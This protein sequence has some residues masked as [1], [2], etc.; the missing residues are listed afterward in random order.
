MSNF[1]ADTLDNIGTAINAPE[2]G[3]SESAAGG[4]TTNT[5]R[6]AG[7]QNNLFNTPTSTGLAIADTTYLS[8]L[9][10]Q[11]SYVPTGIT[12]PYSPQNDV[13]GVYDGGDVLGAQARATANS[14]AQYDQAIGT[15]NSSL[16]RLNT[17]ADIARGNVNTQYGTQ[18]GEL[19]TNKTAQQGTYN[20]QTTQN[21]QNLRTNKNTIADQASTGLRGLQRMLGAYGAGGSSDAMFVAP[22]A[23][24]NQASQQ[25]AG[26]GQTFAQN[27]SGLDTNWNNFLGQDTNSRKKLNDWKSN[28]LNS[29]ESQT[30]S[31][32]QDLLSKLADLT[33]QRAAAAGGS[34]AASAQP[35]MDQANALNGTIDNLGRTVSTYD[36]TRPVYEAPTLSSYVSQAATGRIDPT[37][38]TGG[39][40]PYLSMLLNQNK[41]KTRALF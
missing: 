23:V 2:F 36:G 39:V 9:L 18:L 14:L 7:T 35:F 3:W 5:G 20:N 32:R 4:K 37:Q 19:D 30:A 13:S 41:D 40:N 12:S 21:G 28:T 22:Q 29:V 34:Y 17:Q 1:W 6:I 11:P 31:T 15:Y 24:A 38:S 27:Q 10:A 26:A 16:G 25:R 33:G 8:N